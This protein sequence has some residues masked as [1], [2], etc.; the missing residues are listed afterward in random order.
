M[1]YT[2]AAR[3]AAHQGLLARLSSGSTGTATVTV[4]A[5][6]TL[7]GTF[8]LDHAASSVDQ[9]TGVL[10]LVPVNAVVAYAA[11]G[12]A[13]KAQLVARDGTALDD[14]IAVQAGTVAV[15]GKVVLTT[16]AIA[17]ASEARLVS[18]TIG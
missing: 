18:F 11:S 4:Y 3:V 13:N 10:T 15:A 12:T 9:A 14:N 6:T 5:N 16:L 2:A 7:L 8:N 1:S 17:A